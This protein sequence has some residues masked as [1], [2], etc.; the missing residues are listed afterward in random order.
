LAIPENDT[1]AGGA[2][3]IEGRA[4]F[5]NSL[6]NLANHG[7]PL[8]AAVIALPQ[9]IPR[10]GTARFGLR[11]LAWSVIGYFSLF[12]L[13]IGR[14]LTNLVANRIG[15]RKGQQV[16]ELIW[17]ALIL[18]ILLGML[19]SL[20]GVVLVPIL[21]QEWMHIP[22]ELR[23]EAIRSFYILVL[24]VPI[25][26]SSNGMRG[27]IEAYQRF[28][29][30]TR[31]RLPLGMFNFLAPWVLVLLTPDL[32]WIVGVL[33]A[34][35]LSAWIVELRLCLKLVSDLG[36]RMG[37]YPR[38]IAPLFRISA[39]MAISNLVGPL[40]I[41]LDR[42]V[43]GVMLPIALVAYY[44][45]PYEALSR[46]LI[47]PGAIAGVL[48]PSFSTL[49]HQ[50][51]EAAVQILDRACRYFLLLMFPLIAVMIVWAQDILSLWLGPDFAQN[52]AVI[53]KVLALGVFYNSLS[54]MAFAL[55]QG[56]GRPEATVACHLMEMPIYLFA[57]W[58]GLHHY[59]IQGAAYAWLMR[60][61]VDMILLF[62]M[63][64]LLTRQPLQHWGLK[65]MI[66]ALATI[67]MA[68]FFFMTQ[69]AG[70]CL[71]SLFLGVGYP[72][73]AW[74]FGLSVVEREAIMP[75]LI[76]VWRRPDA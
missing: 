43:V 20:I 31:V 65:S 5:R 32:T 54:Q 25:V 55:V 19:S 8:I 52:S 26:I 74:R 11:T 38:L 60:I 69:A 72:V 37:F 1:Q 57:L 76:R 53:F 48:F 47:I 59:G 22:P 71:L 21:I 23:Q 18:M 34:G 7:L 24:A 70:K 46:I 61:I 36:S 33:V 50:D 29:L 62:A 58:Q 41:Y 39:W 10:M 2:I 13:G 45:T 44:T 51:R 64:N 68:G 17:T 56:S 40:M 16:P 28:D 73:F 6:F 42:F 35:R 15:A 67:A 27:V 66:L 14:A 30:V 75:W 63:V 12:D 9:I 49:F 3:R 4:L